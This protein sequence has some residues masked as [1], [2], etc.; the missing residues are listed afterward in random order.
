MKKLQISCV[1]LSY[2]GGARIIPTLESCKLQTYVEKELV[3]ADDASTDK[4][5]T[6]NYI[7]DW[8]KTNSQFFKSVRFIKNEQ[9]LGI[10]KNF[11]NAALNT[12]GDIIF[13]LGQGDM[14]YDKNSL[15][16]LADEITKQRAE[17]KKDPYFW[18]CQYDGYKIK[19]NSVEI[20][21]V[22]KDMPHHHRMIINNPQKA[23]ER[24]L[25]R[26]RI[27]GVAVIHN[28]DFFTDNIYPLLGAPRNWEDGPTF[29]WALA[30][31]HTIGIIP[32]KL[33]MYEVGT[34]ISWQNVNRF[35]KIKN[36]FSKITSVYF[37]KKNEMPILIKEYILWI[38]TIVPHNKK[39]AKILNTYIN[40]IKKTYGEE[41]T[42][43]TVKF[44]FIKIKNLLLNIFF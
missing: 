20:V 25:Y 40:M 14:C 18:L 30:E 10:V 31:G 38:E 17:G 3:I 6:V 1:V 35:I 26:W 12:K 24:N 21:K 5:I 32:F 2:N 13:G 43:S 37:N 22:N 44:T 11:R 4:G 19:D 41:S 39:T 27:G 16:T 7:E 33:R 28:K 23:L 29:L 34:G 36:F 42:I 15:S 8:L 9:N